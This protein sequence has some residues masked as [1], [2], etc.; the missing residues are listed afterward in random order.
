MHTLYM[1]KVVEC[2]IKLELFL[3]SYHCWI[4]VMVNIPGQAV[5]VFAFN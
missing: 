5:H 4:V 3:Q 2:E 1:K